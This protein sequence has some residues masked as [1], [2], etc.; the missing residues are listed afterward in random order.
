MHW[1]G[2]V[3]RL[4][5]VPCHVCA[6]RQTDPD[7][8]PSAWRRLVRRGEQVLVCP[9]CAQRPGWDA[10]ADRCA[11]CGSSALSKSL[12]VVRCKACGATAVQD[13]AAPSAPD[14]ADL[15][16]DVAAAVDRIFG[17]ADRSDA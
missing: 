11:A 4:T 10:D 6:K 3:V 9:E 5:I 2:T 1:H 16:E 13:A 12:G 17:R 15:A 8:G 14:P 7:R